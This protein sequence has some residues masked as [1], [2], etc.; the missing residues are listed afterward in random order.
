M[1]PIDSTMQ[2]A[3]SGNRVVFVV[4][5]ELQFR[6]GIQRYCTAGHDLVWN[7]YTWKGLGGV[8]SIE[9]IQESAEIKSIGVRLSLSGVPVAMRS[10]ALNEKPQGT[11]AKLWVAVYDESVGAL[12]GTP[13]AEYVGR[14]DT[15]ELNLREGVCTVSVNVESPLADLQRPAGGRFTDADQQSRFPGDKF[16]EFVP[17]QAERELIFFSKEQQYI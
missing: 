10:L 5:A 16:F 9:P 2:A 3:L 4:F 11:F 12:V 7:S 17:Q 6:T 14:M 1:K 13:M 15:L 8:V